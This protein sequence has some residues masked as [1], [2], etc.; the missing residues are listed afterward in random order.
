MRIRNHFISI[1]YINDVTITHLD[2]KE[3][4]KD[5]PNALIFKF[6]KGTGAILHKEDGFDIRSEA[7]IKKNFRIGYLLPL[8]EPSSIDEA[9][10]IIEGKDSENSYVWSSGK[11]EEIYTQYRTY[12]EANKHYL[13]LEKA[14]EKIKKLE[15]KLK[16]KENPM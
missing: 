11:F 1:S 12:L 16:K 14:R 6:P 3:H 7:Y 15:S 13:E 2:A 10:S 8:I 4:F 5:Y 9:T